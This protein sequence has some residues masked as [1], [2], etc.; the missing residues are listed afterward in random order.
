VLT[1]NTHYFVDY[2]LGQFTLARGLAYV[3]SDIIKVDFHGTTNDADEEI[4]NPAEIFKYAMNEWLNVPDADLDL[5]SIYDTKALKT[6][7]LSLYLWK[8]TGSQDLVR[9]IEQSSM[10]YSY[11]DAH[12][13]LGLRVQQTAGATGIKYIPSIFVFDFSE[14]ETQDTIYSTVN[15]YYGE[16]PSQDKY[17][18]LT[19]TANTIPWIY[20]VA[21]TLDVY[22]ALAS[23]TDAGTLGDLIL[24]DLNKKKIRFNV[25]RSLYKN[26]PGD[27]IYFSRERFYDLSGT[28]NTKLI[29]IVSISKQYGSGK[30]EITGE[31]I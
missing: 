12:G 9:R 23:A 5:D 24:A 2:G 28:A 3:E 19:K 10:T 14:D 29:R 18:L 7:A 17:L 26:F 6:T 1:E 27:L 31:V 11:Q 4:S 25:P 30:T 21:K 15:I 13:R 20:R 8:E 22:V 16:N